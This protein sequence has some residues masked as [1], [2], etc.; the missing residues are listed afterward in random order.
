M[1]LPNG[2]GSVYRLTGNRRRPW[3]A[4]VTVLHLNNQWKYH[5]LGYY[6]SRNDAL[7]AL[8]IYNEN[9]YDL[10]AG[11]ISF[12]EVYD[13]WSDEHFRR[14]SRSNALGYQ[15]AYS[16]CKPLYDL[17]FIDIRRL[18]LQHII[19]TCG[20]N[21]PTLCRIKLLFTALYKYALQNDICGKDY[22]RFVDLSQYVD[23][24]PNK[25]THRPFEKAE[26]DKLWAWKETN[27]YIGV[28]LILLYTGFRIGELLSLKKEN[29]NVKERYFDVIAAKTHAGIRRVPMAEKIVPLV[30]LWME[31]SKNE[32]LIC[33][34]EGRPFIYRNFTDSYWTPLMAELNMKHTCHDTR[35]TCISLLARAGVDEK[36]IRRIVGHKGIGVTEIVYTHFD[37]E[38]LLTAINKI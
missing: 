18:H 27:E 8:A 3:T 19:D 16:C 36:I 15:S 33:T 14:I 10:D 5:Y 38:T 7:T 20:K 21:Y 2:Y 24:N 37:L 13:R 22:A 30:E 12:A 32:F 34:M 1:K 25:R 31:H 35:H 9:P 29:V 17:R 23:R 28:F 11:R 26:I 6:E 4:R